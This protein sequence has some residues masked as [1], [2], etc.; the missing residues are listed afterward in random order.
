MDRLDRVIGLDRDSSTL[1]AQAGVSV[2]SVREAASSVGLWCPA[3][4]WL[5]GTSK[6]GAAFAGGHG[7]RSRSYGTVADHVLGSRFICPSVGVVRHGGKAIKNASGF[8]L[9]AAVAGSRGELGVVLDLTLRLVP[10]PA[11]RVVRR[12]QFASV[13]LAFENARSLSETSLQAAAVEMSVRLGADSA[14]VLVEVEDVLLANVERRLNHLTDRAVE[15]GGQ[16]DEPVAR[17]TDLLEFATTRRVS[18]DPKRL[19]TI[20]RQLTAV[21]REHAIVGSIVAEATSGAVEL[22]FS[23]RSS[24]GLAAMSDLLPN[25]EARPDLNAF[26]GMFKSA[27]D[28]HGLLRSG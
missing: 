3:L 2:D 18:L 28:P 12:F 6:I 15:L 26:R 19:S 5:S 11:H 21:C 16:I 27:F 20:G 25:L 10:V 23:D 9:S 4:R 22:N 13:E 8:N 7:R 17:P 14:H 1:V 24:E